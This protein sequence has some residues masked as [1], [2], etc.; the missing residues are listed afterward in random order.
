MLNGLR[1]GGLLVR[2]GQDRS[3]VAVRVSIAN[4]IDGCLETGLQGGKDCLGLR[5]E[6]SLGC[7]QCGDAGFEVFD[8]LDNLVAECG[9][10]GDLIGH[11]FLQCLD[12]GY[13]VGV[14]LVY[15]DV[16]M[17]IFYCHHRNLFRS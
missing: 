1:R 3:R 7:L 15:V 16:D 11:E 4:T 17:D 13:E 2:R 12:S 5:G 9:E 14:A 8:K 6:L 10:F